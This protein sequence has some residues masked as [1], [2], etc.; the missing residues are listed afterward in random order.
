[1][2]RGKRLKNKQKSK[3][4]ICILLIV[5]FCCIVYATFIFYNDIKDKKTNESLKNIV[6]TENITNEKTETIL[7]IEELEKQNTDIIGW[8]K[9]NDTNIDSP[10]VKTSDNDFYLNHNYLKENSKSG[11]IFLDKNFDINKT[12]TNYLIYGHRNKNGLMFEDLLKYA[13]KKFYENHKTIEFATKQEDCLYEIISIFYSRVYYKNE[14]N[15]FRY[16]YFTNAENEDEYNNFIK[17]CKDVS[18]Y[19]TGVSATYGEQLLTLSTCEYSQKDGRFVIV[20]KKIN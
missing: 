16:Y 17:N 2:K 8:L 15:V 18:I 11:A 20:A 10:V 9:I 1:M 4:A 12:S 13:D 3:V 19:D 6:V 5:I 14:E 7:K